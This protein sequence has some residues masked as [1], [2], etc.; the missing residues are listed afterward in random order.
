[1]RQW[2]RRSRLSKIG[3]HTMPPSARLPSAA[4]GSSHV[5]DRGLAGDAGHAGHTSGAKRTDLSP[6]HS[7]VERRANIA[8]RR[9]REQREGKWIRREC[10][11]RCEIAKCR[12]GQASCVCNP[13]MEKVT[14]ASCR[15]SVDRVSVFKNRSLGTQL[16]RASRS[17]T[18]LSRRRNSRSL[19]SDS[20]PR[21]G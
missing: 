21:S 12:Y 17:P 7:G 18:I 4:A 20:S 11:E 9:L 1:M 16:E 13:Q 8:G 2:R 10:G 6:L 14:P 15:S 19:H 5:V 3:F